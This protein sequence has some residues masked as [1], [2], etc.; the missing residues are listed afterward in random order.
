MRQFLFEAIQ[1]VGSF[2][3]ISFNFLLA[4]VACIPAGYLLR[5]ASDFHWMA[6]AIAV[7]FA[8]ATWGTT[9]CLFVVIIKN[10][11]GKLKPG[12]YP[13]L[14][15]TAMRWAV[16]ARLV[17]FVHISFIFCLQGTAFLNLWFRLLGAKIGKRVLVNAIDISDWDL[18]TIEDDAM[19]GAG[20]V[21]LGHVGEMGRLKLEPVHIGKGCNVGRSAVIFPGT[22]LEDGSVLGAQSLLTKGKRL[23]ANTIWGG[24]PAEFIRERGKK[25]FTPEQPS[26]STSEQKMPESAQKNP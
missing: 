6:T 9:M 19:L 3:L 12:S 24:S 10:L 2:I 4:G 15:W 23:P 8:Y 22:T 5:F 16:V 14:S 11:L 1:V 25:D 21:I 26:E 7:P 20:V 13:F 18:V 17:S